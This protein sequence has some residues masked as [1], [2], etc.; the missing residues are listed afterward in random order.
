[1]ARP[2]MPK[3]LRK[4]E[5]MIIRMTEE[6]KKAVRREARKLR[7]SESDYGRKHIPELA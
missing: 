4:S 1:M 3:R 6:E 7:L 2:R 5:Q